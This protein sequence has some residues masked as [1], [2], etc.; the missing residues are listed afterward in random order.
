M[1]KKEP[2]ISLVPVE[3][4]Q[5]EKIGYDAESLTLEIEFAGQN[6]YRY[7]DVP[8]AVYDAI[9]EAESKGSAFI[10][11]IKNGGFKYRKMPKDKK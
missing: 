6:H 8:K 11:L 7:D 9:M 1:D 10:K 3:S 5:F 4:S 2:S